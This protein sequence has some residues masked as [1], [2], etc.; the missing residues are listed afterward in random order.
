MKVNE[1]KFLNSFPYALNTKIEKVAAIYIKATTIIAIIMALKKL[2]S[3]L[4][5]CER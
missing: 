4:N 2:F 5:S 1:L 3:F